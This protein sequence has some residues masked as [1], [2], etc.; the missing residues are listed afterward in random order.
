MRLWTMPVRSP[1]RVIVDP[2]EGRSFSVVIGTADTRVAIDAVVSLEQ[3]CQGLTARLD[4]DRTPSA[5]PQHEPDERAPP[6]PAHAP[7]LPRW[8]AVSGLHRLTHSAP[9]IADSL[10]ICRMIIIHLI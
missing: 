2:C 8:S 7:E 3:A 9:L 1:R 5:Q 10:T 6:T 4:C